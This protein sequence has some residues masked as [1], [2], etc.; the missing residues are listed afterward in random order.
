MKKIADLLIIN[1]RA[2]WMAIVIG[3]VLAGYAAL[4]FERQTQ[5]DGRASV[6]QAE[7]M[8]AASEVA[9]LSLRGNVMGVVSLLGRLDPKVKSDVLRQSPP[10]NPEIFG[11]FS[12]IGK[13]FDADA[14]FV[15]DPDGV[16]IT[17]WQSYGG[18][19]TGDQ[20]AYRL[21]F[22]RAIKG[23]S[24]IYPAISAGGQRGLFYAAPIHRTDSAESDIIGVIVVRVGLS[25]I[26][27]TLKNHADLAALVSPMGIVFAATQSDWIG[28][29]SQ[30]M[31]A[32]QKRLITDQRQFGRVI[33]ENNSLQ[34]SSASR[35]PAMTLQGREYLTARMP[36]SL[37]DPQGDWQLVLL[38]DIEHAT[39]QLRQIII[40][41]T[42]GS[43][44][45][46]A[47]GLGF[48]M[49]QKA[50]AKT[51][52]DIQLRQ[53]AQ[54]QALVSERK[55]QITEVA[56]E[57][58]KATDQRSLGRMFLF[59]CYRLIEATHGV[60]YVLDPAD[61]RQLLLIA[62]FA[63]G[64][65]SPSVINLGEGLLG[66]CAIDQ[67]LTV[68]DVT[69]EPVGP[70]GRPAIDWRITSGLGDSRPRAVMIA[71]IMANDTFIGVV[72]ISSLS[73]LNEDQ[74]VLFQELLQFL[75]TGL[76][77]KST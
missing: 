37:N 59:E 58:S 72:E 3:S 23:E 39:S 9:S 16:L 46:I 43:L 64:A 71:P 34:L 11:V 49:V 33:D 22:Q 15:A 40:A 6:L 70:T 52:A 14:V 60:I 4:L 44:T 26:D 24:N 31:T 38:E 74:V 8:G 35:S 42:T 67:N 54:T 1:T 77:L 25:K 20:I 45:L 32:E 10:N 27:K 55:T 12:V 48:N 18:I 51:L 57:L 30:P 7:A 2:T 47:L 69:D 68:F 63:G 13:M 73:Q 76:L 62:G 50:Q 56:L 61:S 17:T 53:F 75:A 65:E 29:L 28:K 19:S 21:Y 5:M 66:Q 41:A 36:L